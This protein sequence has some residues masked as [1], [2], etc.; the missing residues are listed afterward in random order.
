MEH[1]KK[2]PKC[3][4]NLKRIPIK[5]LDSVMIVELYCENCDTSITLYPDVNKIKFKKPTAF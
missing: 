2:C 5:R 3:G 4:S 1:H